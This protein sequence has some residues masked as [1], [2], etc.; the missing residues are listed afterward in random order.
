MM[1][2]PRDPKLRQQYAD[3]AR[4]L[5]KQ[6][7]RLTP[8]HISTELGSTMKAVETFLRK[9]R[10]VAEALS[11][12][13]RPLHN[14]DDYRRAI[15]KLVA[16]EKKVTHENI[17]RELGLSKRGTVTH[18]LDEHP[19]LRIEYST[20]LKPRRLPSTNGR[21]RRRDP[22][23]LRQ[24]E[25]AVVTIRAKGATPTRNKLAG[26]LG[27]SW[28]T[29]HLYL[30]RNPDI[31]QVLGIVKEGHTVDDYRQAVEKVA[32]SCGKVKQAE[33][34]QELGVS[35]AGTVS[36]FL[37]NHPEVR[38]E[39]PDALRPKMK[40][41]KPRRKKVIR[42]IFKKDQLVIVS[43]FD[44]RSGQM[45]PAAVSLAEYIRLW[46]AELLSFIQKE[47]PTPEHLPTREEAA[48]LI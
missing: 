11:V 22:K 44:E 20:V 38:A 14:A 28:N 26:E 21:G 2:R 34:A 5:R 24:Y 12:E 30:R 31:E 16:E 40:H 39:Y 41:R 46:D 42:P 36:R 13:I 35:A 45:R 48:A 27:K 17:S 23:I 9:N 7:R 4:S 1:G 18:F 29:V 10:D 32:A 8:Q 15:D 43:Y 37:D 47:N 33:V 6:K 25:K 3:A 19:E